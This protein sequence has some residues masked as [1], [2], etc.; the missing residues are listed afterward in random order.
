MAEYQSI[1]TGQQ[2]DNALS[3]LRDWINTDG[4]YPTVTVDGITYAVVWKVL[5]T[6]SNQVYG[7]GLYSNI[8]GLP[9]YETRNLLLS[10]L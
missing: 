7:I 10:N 4:S 6:S 1:F 9:L 5:P 3:K 2:V 8:R